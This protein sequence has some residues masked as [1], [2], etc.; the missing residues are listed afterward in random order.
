[1]KKDI[2]SRTFVE[3]YLITKED[4]N[5]FDKCVLHLNKKPDNNIQHI[6]PNAVKVRDVHIQTENI[7]S[8]HDKKGEPDISSSDEFYYNSPEKKIEK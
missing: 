4:K 3:M 2:G 6:Q 1:M 5:L 8:E 7:P